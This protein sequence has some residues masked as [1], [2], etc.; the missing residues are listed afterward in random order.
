MPEFIIY[1]I[2]LL[3]GYFLRQ[4]SSPPFPQNPKDTKGYPRFP[5]VPNVPFLQ[6]NKK[7]PVAGII[8]DPTPEELA[9]TKTEKEYNNVV[10]K[11]IRKLMR[12]E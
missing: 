9:E 1:L 3:V 10:G 8:E 4:P 2:F 7:V 12:K 6:K 11:T 5:N